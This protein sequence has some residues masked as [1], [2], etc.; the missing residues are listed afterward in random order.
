VISLA[1]RKSDIVEEMLA[2][3]VLVCHRREEEE[4][5]DL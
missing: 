2:G 4:E 3:D 5:E 1:A